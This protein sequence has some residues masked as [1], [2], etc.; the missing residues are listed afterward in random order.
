MGMIDQK[1]VKWQELPD[2]DYNEI[3]FKYDERSLKLKNVKFD[4]AVVTGNLQC[5]I[6]SRLNYLNFRTSIWI[7]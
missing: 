3:K 4:N 6:I 7:L 1:T 2:V 5:I